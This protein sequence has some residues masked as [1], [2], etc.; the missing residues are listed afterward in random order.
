VNGGCIQCPAGT[1]FDGQQ[2]AQTSYNTKCN[3][4]YSFYN[5]KACA[6]IQNYYM[7]NGG[8]CISCPKQYQWSGISCTP[9]GSSGF[10]GGPSSATN[11]GLQ[12]SATVS[13]TFR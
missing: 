3:D 6:C 4:P 7:M 5:G 2:C 1:T 12:F 10:I 8:S 11:T 9:S 13:A